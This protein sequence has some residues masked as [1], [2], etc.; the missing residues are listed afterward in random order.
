I[1]FG[2]AADHRRP[3]GQRLCAQRHQALHHQCPFRESRADHG[4]HREGESAPQRAC[5]GLSRSDGHGRRHG[6]QVRQKD[7]PVRQPHRRH[8]PGGR[9]RARR[10]VAGWRGRQGLHLPDERTA[11]GA[12]VNRGQRA[13]IGPARV[14]RYRGIHPRSQGV[15]QADP[16][17]P[18]HPLHPGRHQGQAAGGSG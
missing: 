18:E 10:R 8:H 12:S 6:G 4:A 2:G 15:R 9:V 11:A 7:G 16:R 14:R 3:F 5:L 13:G 1:G 17:F